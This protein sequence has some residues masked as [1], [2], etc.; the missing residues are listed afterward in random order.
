MIDEDSRPPA[1]PD[2][3]PGVR[4]AANRQAGVVHKFGLAMMTCGVDFSGNLGGVT[5]A[6]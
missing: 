2:R 1:T 3:T 5:S 4:A 6:G